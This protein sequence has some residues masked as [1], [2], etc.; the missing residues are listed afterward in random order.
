[1]VLYLG[2]I[3]VSPDCSDAP[4]KVAAIDWSAA[5]S[6][7]LT[8]VVPVCDDRTGLAAFADSVSTYGHCTDG[9][10][11]ETTLLRCREGGVGCGCVPCPIT[12]NSPLLVPD[13]VVLL[14]ADD[15]L[16]INDTEMTIEF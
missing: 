14:S 7:M 6:S 2:I 11:A 5:T 16:L 15:T 12:T 1:M 13:A 9:G 8:E 4:S 10:P 3:Q